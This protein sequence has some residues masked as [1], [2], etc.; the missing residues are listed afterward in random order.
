MCDVTHHFLTLHRYYGSASKLDE[1]DVIIIPTHDMTDTLKD[2]TSLSYDILFELIRPAHG[3]SEVSTTNVLKN[4]LQNIL[5]THG[6]LLVSGSIPKH[7]Q[8][9]QKQG[10]RFVMY[11]TRNPALRMSDC[12]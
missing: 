8:N 4:I 5:M 3:T 9:I 2:I 12:R 1:G 11:V 7:M 6:G 10:I